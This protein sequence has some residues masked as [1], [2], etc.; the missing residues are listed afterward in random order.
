MRIKSPLRIFFFFAATFLVT[1]SYLAQASDGVPDK[2]WVEKA[3]KGNA[4]DQLHLGQ[5]YESKHMYSEAAR[6][7]SRSARQGNVA[8]E[9][10]LGV[11][12][13]NGQGVSQDY[14]EAAK[15]YQAAAK[16]GNIPAEVRLG[17]LCENGKGIIQDRTE[18]YMWFSVAAAQH[19]SE[20][21]KYRDALEKKLTST[22]IAAGKHVAHEWMQEHSSLIIPY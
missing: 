10:H 15:W 5:W 9:Y 7:F 6:W 4:W 21:A 22:E 8:A 16:H 11:L 20:A 13:E 17:I 14:V 12:Y 1:L 3:E 18:A 19:S 2:E